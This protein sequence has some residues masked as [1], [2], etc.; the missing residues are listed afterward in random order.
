MVGAMDKVA[1]TNWTTVMHR[2][3]SCVSFVSKGI[4][5]PKSRIQ[6]DCNEQESPVVA[7][8]RDVPV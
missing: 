6:R 4:Q 1:S 3:G 5:G 2:K 8:S 7:N